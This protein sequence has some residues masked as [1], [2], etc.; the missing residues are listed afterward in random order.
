MEDRHAYNDAVKR[1][2]HDRNEQAKKSVE[3][4]NIG[5]PVCSFIFLLILLAK[6]K[7]D[8]SLVHHQ[9]CLYNIKHLVY[10]NSL[11]GEYGRH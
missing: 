3:E 8:A 1:K 5:E 7:M 9:F 6:L 4:K 11:P 10:I 2:H